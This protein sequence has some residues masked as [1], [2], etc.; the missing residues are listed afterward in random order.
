M[1]WLV[2][3]SGKGLD[4]AHMNMH[5]HMT[6][7]V[8]IHSLFTPLPNSLSNSNHSSPVE[9]VDHAPHTYAKHS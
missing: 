6:R 5:N 3:T 7:H 2:Y 1:K 8:I 4:G 9:L